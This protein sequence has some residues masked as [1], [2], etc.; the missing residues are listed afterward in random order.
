MVIDDAPLSDVVGNV[1]TSPL[2]VVGPVLVTP[3]PASTAKLP[4]VPSPTGVWAAS[5]TT[6]GARTAIPTVRMANGASQADRCRE[7]G[8]VSTDDVDR[9]ENMTLPLPWN[10]ERTRRA[11][12]RVPV[13]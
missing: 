8:D 6:A 4:A 1:P 11:S 13:C 9:R 12:L 7:R 10:N 5:A 3:V 2:T